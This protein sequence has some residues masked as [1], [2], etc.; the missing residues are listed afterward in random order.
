[1]LGLRE[2]CEGGGN[3]GGRREERV[4]GEELEIYG[5]CLCLKVITNFN[6]KFLPPIQELF[7]ANP[8]S[9]PFQATLRAL[10]SASCWRM[11]VCGVEW[12]GLSLS[13]SQSIR[14]QG[15]TRYSC[16]M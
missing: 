9:L 7:P 14:S 13:M 5:E 8:T 12:R 4:G 10:A 2:V 16:F 3:G 6:F 1:M 15:G 11:C